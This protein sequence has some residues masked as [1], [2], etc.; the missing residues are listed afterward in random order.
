MQ[1][2][3][4]VIYVSKPYNLTIKICTH[5]TFSLHSVAL[6]MAATSCVPPKMDLV[7][8]ADLHNSNISMQPNVLAQQSTKCASTRK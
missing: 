8:L 3:I 2:I 1:V 7:G 4:L 6:R 5:A